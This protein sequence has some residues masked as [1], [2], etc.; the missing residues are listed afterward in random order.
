M[1]QSGVDKTETNG[2]FGCFL[3]SSF[4]KKGYLNIKTGTKSKKGLKRLSVKKKKERKVTE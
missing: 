4:K 2:T 1:R 3:K